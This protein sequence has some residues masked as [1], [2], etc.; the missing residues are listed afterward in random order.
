MPGR[1][2]RAEPHSGM[3]R[4]IT[5]RCLETWLRDVL[6]Q[7]TAPATLAGLGFC[8]GQRFFVTAFWLDAAENAA[9]SLGAGARAEDEG[10]RGGSRLFVHDRDDVGVCL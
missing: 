1:W 3:T 9:S 2:S 4:D 5:P 8:P 10:S 6:N 7:H